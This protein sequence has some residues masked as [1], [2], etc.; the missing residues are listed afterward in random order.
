MGYQ[1]MDLRVSD[2]TLSAIK[3]RAVAE[4]IST[5]EIARRVLEAA[6]D[7]PEGEKVG[8]G[9]GGEPEAIRKVVEELLGPDFAKRMEL[10]VP[11]WMVTL[12]DMNLG[13]PPARPRFESGT[14]IPPEVVRY[15]VETLAHL[16]NLVDKVLPKIH[17]TVATDHE[18][19]DWWT[20]LPV[21]ALDVLEK[22]KTGGEK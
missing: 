7:N 17:V 2:S 16:Y 4:G 11:D 12:E 13:S 21:A 22:L 10:L 19:R 9:S 20:V 15:L 8:S 14:G 6:F 5:S 1:R 18:L 3:K